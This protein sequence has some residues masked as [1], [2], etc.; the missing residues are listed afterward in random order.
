VYWTRRLLVLLVAGALAVGVVRVLGGGEERLGPVARPASGVA[1][2][3]ASPLAEATSQARPEPPRDAQERTGK[4]SKKK[5]APKRTRAPL[6]RPSGPCRDSDVKVVPRLVGN[7][8]A[9]EDVRVMLRLSTYE[10]PA[11]TW[12]VSS[13]TV[14]VRLTSG[15]DRIWS[16][17]DCPAAVPTEAVVLRNRRPTGVEVVWPGRRSDSDCSRS[18]SW[19]QPGYYHVAAAAMGSEPESRQFELRS[20]APITI[21]PTPT[22]TPKNKAR[23]DGAAGD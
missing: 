16:T 11:C 18:T 20:P 8:Y 1:T 14:A 7:A 5:K 12:E 3:D 6:A 2:D 4:G 19:A 21:T 15:S 23:Q 22:P 9:G 17:Q 10:S 13:D